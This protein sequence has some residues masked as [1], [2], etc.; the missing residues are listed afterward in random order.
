VQAE[1]IDSPDL[2]AILEVAGTIF[3]PP[4]P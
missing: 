4:R 3:D 2:Q 1:D